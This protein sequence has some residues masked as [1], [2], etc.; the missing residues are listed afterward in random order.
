MPFVKLLFSWLCG[1]DPVISR[2]IKNEVDVGGHL[3]LWRV[4]DIG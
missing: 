1:R 4:L 2:S 3:L